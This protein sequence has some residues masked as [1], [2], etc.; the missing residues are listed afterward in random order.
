MDYN[1]LFNDIFF[2][3][4]DDEIDE[5]KYP[6]WKGFSFI[7]N[8]IQQLIKAQDLLNQLLHEFPNDKK[9]LFLK[10]V[11]QR[12]LNFNEESILY[13]LEAKKEDYYLFA[14]NFYI[15]EYYIHKLK[16]EEALKYLQEI[17]IVYPMNKRFLFLS[18][19][20]NIELFN[21]EE[22][23]RYLNALYQL[24][25]DKRVVELLSKNIQITEEI[26]LKTTN[27]LVLKNFKLKSFNYNLQL[28][29]NLISFYKSFADIGV[30]FNGI[31][32]F[33]LAL[34]LKQIT[35]YPIYNCIEKYNVHTVLDFIDIDK[36]NL[37][38]RLE[39]IDFEHDFVK[40][41]HEYLEVEVLL[42]ED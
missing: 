39:D 36:K 38:M 14:A 27:R 34:T 11:V 7:H 6:I 16:F 2:L 29:T 15:A 40:N 4:L 35:L 22:A 32:C 37:Q 23:K 24:V 26:V 25:E 8:P 42:K 1:R 30:N 13:L 19:L 9:A 28:K 18:V 10:G 5:N 20:V 41:Y 31:D 17:E 3:I 21:L 33:V 12:N